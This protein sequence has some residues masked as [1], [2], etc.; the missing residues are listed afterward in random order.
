LGETAG[1][2][3]YVDETKKVLD[4]QIKALLISGKSNEAGILIR[5]KNQMI[6]EAD[7]QIPGYADARKLYAGKMALID[8]S[9]LGNEIFNTPSRELVQLSSALTAQEK[10]AYALGAKNAIINRIDSIGMTRNQVMAL[11]GKN[12]DAAKLR[13]LFD[14]PEQADQ[15]LNQLRRETEFAITRNAVIGNSNTI[16]QASQLNNLVGPGAIRRGINQATQFV[17]GNSAQKASEVAG[18]I[19]GLNQERSSEMYKSALIKAG[20]ILLASGM[21][22]N[23]LDELL[24]RGADDVIGAE[25]RKIIEPSFAQRSVALTGITVQQAISDQEQQ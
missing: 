25:L 13:T 5:F 14:S 8:A 1:T 19:D 7:Q 17:F 21:N 22:I 9:E 24:R 12:G 4:D 3:D 20:D 10:T 23:R 2:F 16:A 6:S 11:F 18:I 15:F